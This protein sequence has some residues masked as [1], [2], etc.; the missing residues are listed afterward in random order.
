M[1]Q[2]QRRHGARYLV[3]FV[4]VHGSECEWRRLRGGGRV[5][6]K[7]EQEIMHQGVAPLLAEVC[8]EQTDG[9]I[10]QSAVLVVF[11]LSAL[12]RSHTRRRIVRNTAS[13]QVQVPFQIL[14]ESRQHDGINLGFI[15]ESAK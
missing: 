14:V 9:R 12:H 15:F 1:F 8:L 11:L 2:L 10:L 6:A 5:S 7:G 13:H 3:D 4:L